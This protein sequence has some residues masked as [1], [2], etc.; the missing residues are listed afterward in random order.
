MVV[1]ILSL[2][3]I[4]TRSMVWWASDYV[5]SFYMR[6]NCTYSQD[7][8]LYALYYTCTSNYID[9]YETEKNPYMVKAEMGR[10]VIDE[11]SFQNHDYFNC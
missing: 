5:A 10:F 7:V 2:F 1:F 11:P 8:A 3:Y 4:L 9:K 6:H